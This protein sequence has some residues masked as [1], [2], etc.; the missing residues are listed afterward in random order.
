MPHSLNEL[1]FF[2]LYELGKF[3]AY[4]KIQKL[5]KIM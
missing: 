1:D 2:L 5:A 3:Q 4:F